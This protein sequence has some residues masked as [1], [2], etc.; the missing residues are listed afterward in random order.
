[1]PF[2]N[3]RFVSLAYVLLL[4]GEVYADETKE[5]SWDV[6]PV[7]S[8]RIAVPKGWRNLDK[9]GGQRSV[10]FRSGDGKGVP[11]FDETGAPLQTGMSIDKLPESK[12]SLKELLDALVKEAKNAPRLELVGKESVETIKLSDGTEAMFLTV[13]FIK[14]KHRRSLYMK[15]V[16]NDAQSNSWVITGHLVGGKESKVPTADSKLAKWLRAH[17][18]SFTFDQTKFDEKKVQEAYRDRDKK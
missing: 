10:L 3:P 5:K 2:L 11:I 6:V 15:L 17:L 18:T 9:I 16:V 4:T 1:M 8:A 12:Q 13:E 14:E 7:D